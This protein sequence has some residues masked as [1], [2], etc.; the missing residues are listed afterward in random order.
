MAWCIDYIR[1]CSN[2]ADIPPV[3]AK[4]SVM[5]NVDLA[6][7]AGSARHKTL[8]NAE[9]AS[10]CRGSCSLQL[11]LSTGSCNISSGN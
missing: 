11:I 8:K 6:V 3:E 1:S 2:D 4:I 10:C 9:S 5:L 7:S